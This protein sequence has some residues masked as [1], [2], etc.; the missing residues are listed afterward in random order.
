[1]NPD[2][3]S[4]EQKIGQMLLLGFRGTELDDSNPIY[5]DI[6]KGYTGGVIFFDY[7]AEL[8]VH[9]RNV[10]SPEQTQK[11][12][13]DMQ[14]IAS[15]PLFVS[16]DQEGGKVNRLK[17]DYGFPRT[18][19]H[20]EL[21]LRDDP[22]FTRQESSIIAKTLKDLGFNLN[23]A[24]CV[25]L[26]LNK[27]NPIIHGMERAFSEDPELVIK[28]A[29]SYIS[30]HNAQGVMTACKHFP[31]HGSSEADTHLGMVDVTETWQEFETT[32]YK[33]LIEEGLCDAVMT[34]HIFNRKL[35]EDYPATLSSNILTDLLRKKLNFDGLIMTD[36]L[37]MQAITDHFSFEETIQYSLKAGADILDFGNNLVYEPDLGSEAITAILNLLD[38]GVIS[39]ERIEAS[40][41]R[42]WRAKQK[43]L[44]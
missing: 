37:Q 8:G 18:R 39:E 35:D 9:D 29:R 20:W 26:A 14:Q 15:V 19:S 42:I 40:F 31:G 13:G 3:L 27:E 22:D 24:P 11:I 16:V 38:K 4:L 30:A 17:P 5:E 44:F 6:E 28:H 36:D 25:D 34:S 43:W 23:F 41:Q 7:D 12:I 1:M 2:Q 32:P 21:G 10:K 33:K